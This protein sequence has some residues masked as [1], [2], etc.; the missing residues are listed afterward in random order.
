MP[1]HL[2]IAEG[3]HKILPENECD[4]RE[5]KYWEVVESQDTHIHP[6]GLVRDHYST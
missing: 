1:Y 6:G 2:D 4:E 3:K 5:E